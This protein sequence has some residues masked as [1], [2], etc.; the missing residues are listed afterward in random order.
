MDETL[1][2]LSKKK[3]L[4]HFV[5]NEFLTLRSANSSKGKGVAEQLTSAAEVQRQS[6]CA[7]GMTELFFEMKGAARQ[8]RDTGADRISRQLLDS[9][10]RCHDS[11]IAM[12]IVLAGVVGLPLL[13]G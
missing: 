4:F 8:A 11:L 12:A 6:A 7:A 2:R 1:D 3:V 5:S 13:D 10:L 9:S